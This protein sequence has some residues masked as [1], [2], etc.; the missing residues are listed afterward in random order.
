MEAPSIPQA[1]FIQLYA[2]LQVIDMVFLGAY[3]MLIYDHILTLDEE[4]RKIWKAPLSIPKVLF[5]LNRYLTPIFYALSYVEYTAMKDTVMKACRRMYKDVISFAL[6]TTASIMI[7]RV[8]ALTGRNRIIAAGF[9]VLWSI[10][11]VLWII[12]IPLSPL[13]ILPEGLTGCE[14]NP[15]IPLQIIFWIFPM[16]ID[17]LVFL[18]TLWGTKAAGPRSA[19]PEILQENRKIQTRR[20]CT[21]QGQLD[22]TAAA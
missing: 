11:V 12:T 13:Q 19:G 4:V 18:I 21:S 10:Q 2:H 9:G 15:N 5:L 20:D 7:L 22:G 1:E 17:T 6:I 8:Y 14:P 3:V 16:L